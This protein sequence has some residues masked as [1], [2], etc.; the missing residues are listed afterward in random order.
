[1]YEDKEDITKNEKLHKTRQPYQTKKPKEENLDK[2]ELPQPRRRRMYN[3]RKNRRE[4]TLDTTTTT[5]PITKRIVESIT[6][7]I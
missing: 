1:M 4:T 6:V 2:V 7:M 3:T 5:T